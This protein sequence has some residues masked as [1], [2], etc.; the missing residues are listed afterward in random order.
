MTDQDKTMARGTGLSDELE[1]AAQAFELRDFPLAA[2]CLGKV[3]RRIEPPREP[4]ALVKPG[5]PVAEL[6]NMVQ[7]VEDQEFHLA[8]LCLRKAMSGLKTGEAV[9]TL[10]LRDPAA[11]DLLAQELARTLEEGDTSGVAMFLRDL[12]GQVAG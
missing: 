1:K 12:A 8:A 7:A 6:R 9:L 3:L 11:A 10:P 4:G 5:T 2:L